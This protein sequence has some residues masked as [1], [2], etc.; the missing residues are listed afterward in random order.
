MRVTTLRSCSIPT[1]V[2]TAS[3]RGGLC[4][5]D[6]SSTLAEIFSVANRDPR[7]GH[8]HRSLVGVAALGPIRRN[9]G[10]HVIVFFPR[11]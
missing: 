5:A 2:W 9:C 6:S 7:L 1:A 4:S 8:T 11:F 10:D 3:S